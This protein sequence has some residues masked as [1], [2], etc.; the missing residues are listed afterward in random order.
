[1]FANNISYKF[2]PLDPSMCLTNSADKCDCTIYD[3]KLDEAK[4]SENIAESIFSRATLIVGGGIDGFGNFSYLTSHILNEN[5]KIFGDVLGSSNIIYSYEF[6]KLTAQVQSGEIVYRNPGQVVSFNNLYANIY[7]STGLLGLI[8]FLVIL[9][10]YMYYLF[11]NS[12]IINY[13]LAIQLFSILLMFF[14]QAEEI[15]TLLGVSVGLI[16]LESNKN[17]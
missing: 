3:N 4:N 10:R 5:L 9:L 1:M 7:F 17:E 8:W 16:I 14:F 15:S 13:Y 2:P 11:R 12:E 6:E